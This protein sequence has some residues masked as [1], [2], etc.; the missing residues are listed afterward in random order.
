MQHVTLAHRWSPPTAQ[1]LTSHRACSLLRPRRPTRHIAHVQL[2]CVPHAPPAHVC[3]Q[4]PR[5]H[6]P[7]LPC[8]HTMPTFSPPT[9]CAH[10]PE[11]TQPAS[12]GGRGHKPV[13]AS[14]PAEPPRNTGTC[15]PGATCSPGHVL[16]APQRL[17]LQRPGA[18]AGFQGPAGDSLPFTGSGKPPRIKVVYLLLL[19]RASL[20]PGGPRAGPLL[21]SQAGDRPPSRLPRGRGRD[22]AVAAR[23]KQR[24]VPKAEMGP[25]GPGTSRRGC[26]LGGA[27]APQ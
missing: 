21:H 2:L 9:S 23:Q 14:P 16:A 26:G 4:S 19:T 13:W 24:T 11:H 10:T 17:T 22:W 20:G 3:T 15:V 12:P 25:L 1:A 6:S 7:I 8:A 27:L 18:R 5:L